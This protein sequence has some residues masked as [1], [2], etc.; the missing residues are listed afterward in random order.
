MIYEFQCHG[1]QRFH[2]VERPMALAGAPGPLCECG[3][4]THRVY[5]SRYNCDEIRSTRYI[6]PDPAT[7][8]GV[9]VKDHGR[10]FDMGL[11]AWYSSWSERRKLM[12]AK[13]LQ[14]AS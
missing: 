11:G 12:K 10:V 1:C 8:R 7:L 3:S 2:D 4:G 14:E 9:E 5:S 6:K 13:G